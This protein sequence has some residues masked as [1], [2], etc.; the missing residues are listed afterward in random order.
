MTF[1]ADTNIGE[2]FRNG[3]RSGAGLPAALIKKLTKISALKATLG[4]LET[5]CLTS[6]AVAAALFWWTPWAIIPAMII[7]AGRQQACFVLAHDA[8]HYRLYETRWL[9]DF[10]GRLL[11]APVGLS[12]RTYRVLHRLH[13]NILIEHGPQ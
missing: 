1:V 6:L 11:A 13:H 2:E 3:E 7:V 5:I 10:I 9:N 12:M 8:A 4:I